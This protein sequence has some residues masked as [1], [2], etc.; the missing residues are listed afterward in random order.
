MSRVSR[1]LQFALLAAV[2]FLAIWMVAL[3]PSSSSSSSAPQPSTKT[4][5][6]GVLS[7]PGKARAA[8]DAANGASAAHGGTVPT[9]PPAP[10]ASLTTPTAATPTTTPATTTTTPAGTPGVAATPSASALQAQK[11]A[12]ATAP[13]RSA[14]A[15]RLD[16]VS[17]ALKANKVIALLFYNSAASDD[18]AV[19]AELAAIPLNGGKVLRLEVPIRELGRYPVVTTQVPVNSSPTLVI[20][21]PDQQATTIVGF[22]DGFEIAQRIADASSVV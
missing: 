14:T 16:L 7:A 18:R 13:P 21:N 11:R 10:A 6:S 9:A 4:F 1:P 2:A 20:I 3:K 19:K 17:R 22:A 12:Q 8:V 5:A 15:K